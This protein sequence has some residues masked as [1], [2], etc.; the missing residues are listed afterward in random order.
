MGGS[1][2]RLNKDATR[3]HDDRIAGDAVGVELLQVQT[4]SADTPLQSW[5]YWTYK[6]FDDITTQ[7][8]GAESFFNTDGSLQ[9][10]KILALS[11]P[12]A[13]SIGGHPTKM[14][15]DPNSAL[16]AL[17]YYSDVTSLLHL[18]FL[19]CFTWFLLNSTKQRFF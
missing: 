6:S 1:G 19:V 17:S 3:W 13:R 2:E 11:R 16:F 14:Q 15:F 10:A 8:N 5:I 4:T 12:Y 7:N 9:T 18:G